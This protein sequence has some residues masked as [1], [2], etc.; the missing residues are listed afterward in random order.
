MANNFSIGVPATSTPADQAVPQTTQP[1]GQSNSL[2]SSAYGLNP[3]ISQ[4]AEASTGTTPAGAGAGSVQPAE[5]STGTTTAGATGAG[6]ATWN[7][8]LPGSDTGTGTATSTQ[9]GGA[10]PVDT[11]PSGSTSTAVQEF[12][13]LSPQMQAMVAANLQG[14]DLTTFFGALPQA[15][16]TQI[17]QDLASNQNPTTQ[18]LANEFAKLSPTDLATAA[19]AVPS[20]DLQTLV[21]QAQGAGGTTASGGDTPA[22]STGAPA[23]G[24]ESAAVQQYAKFAPQTQAEIA[25]NLPGN[26]V[27][28]FFKALPQAD[29][30]QIQSDLASNQNP[31]AQDIAGE[32]A[33]LNPQDL[34]TAAAAVPNSDLQ[35]LNAEALKSAQTPSTAGDNTAAAPSG[36][37]GGGLLSGGH[38]LLGLGAAGGG[39]FAYKKFIQPRFPNLPTLS[40]VR[41]NVANR[42]S[43]LKKGPGTETPTPD[44]APAA[45]GATREAGATSE[46]LVASVEDG[47]AGSRLASTSGLWTPGAVEGEVPK[48]FVPGNGAAGSISDLVDASGNPLRLAGDA[49]KLGDVARLGGVGGDAAEA[50]V[51]SGALEDG[52][53]VVTHL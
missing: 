4:S 17:Q 31:T 49:T 34:V 38:L 26:D 3:A 40:D 14:N 16:Q 1:E 24:A 27:T 12:S 25:A 51:R 18:D 13:A 2:F 6:G 50:V 9:P 43:F 37:H 44:V 8:L 21:Q 36:S 29:Q 30:T 7:S 48:L 11:A 53:D 20:T 33:K 41:T 32:F 19:A 23:T 52:L 15:D 46:G 5:V 42:F 47:S 35:A 39:L 45:A 28:T 22:S 10:A